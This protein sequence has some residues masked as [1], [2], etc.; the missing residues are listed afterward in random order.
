MTIN[1]LGHSNKVF[2]P[3]E[4]FITTVVS[5][6]LLYPV[7]YLTA[8]HCSTSVVRRRPANIKFA[9]L[10]GFFIVMRT[11][12]PNRTPHILFTYDV[13]ISSIIKNSLGYKITVS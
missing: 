13:P 4:E 1:K 11:K 6:E 2:T 3:R 9:S 8:I 12:M 7:V 5:C 10:K